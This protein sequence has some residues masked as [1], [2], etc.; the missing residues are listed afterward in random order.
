MHLM[1]WQLQVELG[2]R[3]PETLT[4]EGWHGVPDGVEYIGLDN[5]QSVDCAWVW[6]WLR[7]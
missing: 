6:T 5:P 4:N 2:Y 7:G 1:A 3:H